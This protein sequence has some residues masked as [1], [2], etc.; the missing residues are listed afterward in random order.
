MEILKSK[1]SPP[2]DTSKPLHYVI[3]STATYHH[4]VR[5]AWV[6]VPSIINPT[7]AGAAKRKTD[8]LDAKLL[9]LHD[10]TSIWRESFIVPAEVEALRLM[11]AGRDR[12]VS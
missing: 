7:L 4:P 8:R 12:Y 11:I 3:E 6:G 9:A 5:V 1:S 10:Q 2:I